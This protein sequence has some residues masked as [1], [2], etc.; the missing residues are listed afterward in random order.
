MIRRAYEA[1][2][3][4]VRAGIGAWRRLPLRVQGVVSVGL[5]MLAVAVSAG[6]ALFGNSERAAT[7]AAAERHLRMVS[8]LDD[9][10]ALVV[11]AETG[12]RGYLLTQRGEF[13]EPYET[14]TRDLPGALD[15]IRVV[16]ESEPAER[17]REEKLR[18]VEGIR[19]LVAEQMADLEL[20]RAYVP[21][22]RSETDDL[23]EHLFK[24]KALM[25]RIRAE[26][27]AV[28]SHEDSLLAARFAEIEAVRRR[29]YW[30][31]LVTLGLAVVT[32]V[33]SWYLFRTGVTRRVEQLVENARAMRRGE[34]LPHPPTDRVDALGDL[35]RE[36]AGACDDG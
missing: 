6:F 35:E 20:Q 14:A 16:A 24:G 8:A 10:L 27:G 21:R 30:V 25:D 34:P 26:L 32:R 5:P 15:E 33:V 19:A 3:R 1:C 4:G 17:P 18:R 13:L 7:E 36:L 11:N 28:E 23:H 22:R 9:V 31:I 29:D 2:A 12:M